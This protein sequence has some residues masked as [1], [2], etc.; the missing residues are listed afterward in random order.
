MIINS[1]LF[2]K[3]NS[4]VRS[5]EGKVE[6]YEGSTLLNT[7]K[8][9]DALIGF[10]VERV[11]E[12][13]FFGYGVCQKINIKLI[14]KNRELDITTD[15]SF[16]V[17]LDN[18][19]V[20]PIFYVTEVHRDEVTNA[21]SITAYDCI[22]NADKHTVKDL[23]L[24]APY[25]LIEFLNTL[26]FYLS[27]DIAV[28]TDANKQDF[29]DAI[30]YPDGANFE[31]TENLREALNAIAEITQC[32]YFVDCDDRIRFRS[33]T[34]NDGIDFFIDKSKYINLE[35][36]TNR[37][38][39]AI[40]A[41][42]ELGENI[43]ATI[44]VNGTTQYIRDNPF[45]DLREDVDTILND[46]IASIG[47]LTINQFECEW[48]GNYLV[49]IGDKIA[50]ETKEGTDVYSYLLDDV[51]EYDGSLKQK[52]RWSYEDN[53]TE[54]ASNPSN[55]GVAIKQTF[56][57]VDK[58][59][60]Q[61]E[62]VASEN[63]ANTEAIA[64]LAID[65]QAITATVSKVEEKANS[66]DEVSEEIAIV[67]SQVEASITAED[68]RL[69]IQTELADGVN[70]VVTSTGFTFDDEG[71]TVNKSNSEMK[72]TITEDGMTVYKNDEA[73]LTANNQGVN[74]KNLH[75]TTYLIIGENSRFEDYTTSYGN[76]R[77][78]CFW[79]GG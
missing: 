52:S 69:E 36:K 27:G 4:P 1:E 70:K 6:L 79:I 72:T 62:L 43:T 2:N 58:A 76:A 56:A 54:T 10:T 8:H 15:N 59:N 24:S 77:T 64:A 17:Y 71:L 66:I 26:S 67:K 29:Y 60:K 55:L 65:T 11:G 21:L 45:L 74:A 46:A 31:G 53:D 57:R 30:V 16:K 41:V 63:K 61:I 73:V 51:I 44:N 39:G 12:A 5:I 7:F 9:N 19:K 32:I 28:F 78:G 68:V 22:Y 50:L 20:F 40:S 34:A 35:S 25:S 75:A 18:I 23:N 38:L 3:L 48:R 37:R 13:K 47:E 33:F 49:E 14:D 42:T